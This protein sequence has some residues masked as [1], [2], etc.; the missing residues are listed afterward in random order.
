MGRLNRRAWAPEDAAEY[1]AIL[2]E[3]VDSSK[4]TATR[5]D[6]YEKKLH[7]AIQA[8]RYWARDIQRANERQG[9]AAEIKR[10]QDRNRRALVSYDGRLLSMPVFQGTV[11][12]SS[13]GAVVHQ[14]ELIEVCSWETVAEKRSDEIRMRQAYT[15]RIAYLDK[16]LSLRVLCPES[17]SPKDAADRLGMSLDVYLG[18]SAEAA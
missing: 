8:Q 2:A 5:L 4:D 17:A 18:T 13:T 9:A 15:D 14:R 11:A 10:Y 12:R 16:L 7:D 6:L 1:E 3:V